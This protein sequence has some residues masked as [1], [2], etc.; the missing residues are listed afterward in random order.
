ME[1]P[2]LHLHPHYQAKLADA[3][4]AVASIRYDAPRIFVE[5]HS[6][7]LINRLGALV[8]D[9]KL[10]Q[11]DVQILVVNDDGADGDSSVIPVD[12]DADGM[13]GSNWP[14]GFFSPGWQ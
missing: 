10:N 11:E 4:S 13:L 9:K 14:L 5:T 3:L 8:A 12:F 7:H 1:Q 6:D 2:E